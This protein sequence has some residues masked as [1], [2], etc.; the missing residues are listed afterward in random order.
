M[1]PERPASTVEDGHLAAGLYVHV[2]FCLTRCAYCDFATQACAEVPDGYVDSVLAEAAHYGARL[3]RGAL[4]PFGRFDTLYLGGGTPS[5]LPPAAW[6]PLLFGLRQRLPL[7]GLKE[8]TAEANP[9]DVTA[10]LLDAMAGAG[11]TRVSLGVQSLRDEDLRWLGRRHSA[12]QAQSA[13]RAIRARGLSLAVDLMYGLPRASATVWREVLKQALDLGADHLSCYELTVEPTTPLG[14]RRAA[15]ETVSVD[16]ETGRELFLLTHRFL[17]AAGYAQYEVSNFARGLGHRSRHNQ[18][19]WD[20]QPYLGLGPAAHSFAGRRRWWNHRHLEDYRDAVE[21]CGS[22]TLASECLSDEQLRL[23]RLLLGLRRVDGL[24]GSF[25]CGLEGGARQLTALLEEG[26]LSSAGGRVS[27]TVEGLL[28]SDRL[29]LRFSERPA[30][31]R[32][33]GA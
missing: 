11:V 9:D 6:G 13:A 3:P 21:R 1:H 2:P 10:A 27:P 15:G 31:G 16:E 5:R 19:Y 29:P 7:D 33:A 26:V 24:P 14:A 22:G 25:L 30:R 12:A 20:H 4:A 8:V 17:E 28:L 32:A 18:K 23:E